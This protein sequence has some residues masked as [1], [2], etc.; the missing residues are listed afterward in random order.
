MA[1]QMHLDRIQTI[2]QGSF[3]P[4]ILLLKSHI[5]NAYSVKFTEKS[6]IRIK[7][8]NTHLKMQNLS[9]L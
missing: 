9:L 4:Q 7:Y 6:H 3:T 2:N 5:F 1:I 8:C